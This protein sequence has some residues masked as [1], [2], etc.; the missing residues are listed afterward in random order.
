M[1]LFV[2]DTLIMKWLIRLPVGGWT[3]I[4][5]IVDKTHAVGFGW[6]G[7]GS[8]FSIGS[9]YRNNNNVT[10]NHFKGIIAGQSSDLL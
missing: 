3:V 2:A 1:L 9:V 7:R 5:L 8:L 4:V 6:H 10:V